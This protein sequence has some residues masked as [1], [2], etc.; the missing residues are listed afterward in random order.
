MVG[1]QSLSECIN[2]F[3]SPVCLVVLSA[4]MSLGIISICPILW[5][6]P[7]EDLNLMEVNFDVGHRLC[8][9][10]VNI[11]RIRLLGYCH[12]LYHLIRKSPEC[13]KRF[14]SDG[15]VRDCRF[16]PSFAS[17]SVRALKPLTSD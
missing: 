4:V 3:Y 10:E 11:N 16:I 2:Q 5:Q 9:A 8:L 1:G 14:D 13:F 7:K 6:L 17:D 15:N 12:S